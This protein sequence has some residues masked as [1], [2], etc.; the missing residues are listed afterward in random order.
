M[1]TL[2]IEEEYQVIDPGSRELHSHFHQIVDEGQEQ[3]PDQVKAE[4]HQAMVEV[5]TKVCANI[6]EARREVIC[7]RKKVVELAG[8]HNLKIAAAGTHPFSL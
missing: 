7:L 2:G 1:F 4:M 6:T 3:I 5:G 8:Q